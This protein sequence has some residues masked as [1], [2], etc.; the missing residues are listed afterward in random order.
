MFRG[1]KYCY[2]P[3]TRHQACLRV[4]NPELLRFRLYSA[5]AERVAEASLSEPQK[6]ADDDDHGNDWLHSITVEASWSLV[7]GFILGIIR[8]TIW[9][10]GVSNLLTKSPFQGAY[11]GDLGCIGF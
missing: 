7:S 8:V 1:A 9:V 5:D 3:F 2:G 6:T 4:K 10:I 11:W